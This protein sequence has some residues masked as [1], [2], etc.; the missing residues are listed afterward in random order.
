MDNQNVIQKKQNE[1]TQRGETDKT[2]FVNKLERVLSSSQSS[3]SSWQ[4]IVYQLA[5][6]V[7]LVAVISAIVNVIRLHVTHSTV[8][9]SYIMT[10]FWLALSFAM[11]A[12]YMLDTKIDA[13]VALTAYAVG[14]TIVFVIAL[15][16]PK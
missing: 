6:I 12:P 16:L 10:T 8:H 15:F 5:A 13:F 3:S 9:W 2:K 14:W 7:G 1:L 11:K 4:R